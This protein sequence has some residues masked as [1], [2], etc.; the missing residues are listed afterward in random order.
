MG[1]SITASTVADC[2]QQIYEM[3]EDRQLTEREFLPCN[4]SRFISSHK[5][6]ENERPVNVLLLSSMGRSGSSFLGAL[7]SSLP[8]S[9]YF[10]EPLRR[11][12]QWKLLTEEIGVK[13][14]KAVFTCNLTEPVRSALTARNSRKISL[15][16]ARLCSSPNACFSANAVEA[17]CRRKRFRVVK[18]IRSR[19]S[20]LPELLKDAEVNL[21]VIHL[22]RDP[23]GSITSGRKAGWFTAEPETYCERLHADIHD[24][25]QVQ[26]QFPEKYV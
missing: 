12:E 2:R 13:S 15:Q 3:K 24:G 19:V 25:L 18:T 11:L 4:S 6:A 23:R 1:Y 26:R 22:V 20:W 7:L 10:Y 8:G 14:L 5:E 16:D 9:F 17:A 21:R